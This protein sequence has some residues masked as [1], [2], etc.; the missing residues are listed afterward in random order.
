MESVPAHLSV[1]VV[2]SFRAESCCSRA[3]FSERLVHG[4]KLK[5]KLV[6]NLEFGAMRQTG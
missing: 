1:A 2:F 6:S 5:L 3:V 4:R